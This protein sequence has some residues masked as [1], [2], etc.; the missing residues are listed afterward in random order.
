VA[1][2][3]AVQLTDPVQLCLTQPLHVGLEVQR[4][5]PGERVLVQLDPQREAGLHPGVRVEHGD[6]GGGGEPLVTVEV[7]EVEADVEQVPAR[8]REVA[9][10]RVREAAGREQ[11]GV[12]GQHGVRQL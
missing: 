6:A 4:Q 12:L 11:L 10:L 9:D 2:G 5:Q 8:A 3:V 7:R 1:E